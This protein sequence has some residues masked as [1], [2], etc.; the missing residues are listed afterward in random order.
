MKNIKVKFFGAES[1]CQSCVKMK[2]FFIEECKKL[3][4]PYEILDVEDNVE[5]TEKYIIRNVP[6]LLI[7]DGNKVIGRESGSLSYTKI[8]NYL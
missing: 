5:E 2:P 8:K 6:T 1:W 7:M 4:V 3:K